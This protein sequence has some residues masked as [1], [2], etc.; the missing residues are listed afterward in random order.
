MEKYHWKSQQSQRYATVMSKY[1]SFYT[2]MGEFFNK[3]SQFPWR[4]YKQLLIKQ[5]EK[6]ILN[7]NSSDS[8]M[9]KM[10]I[11]T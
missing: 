4:I 2:K 3:I 11:G 5:T 6:K 9:D 7:I 8:L 10:C 1:N